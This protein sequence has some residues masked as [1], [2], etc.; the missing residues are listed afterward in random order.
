MHLESMEDTLLTVLITSAIVRGDAQELNRLLVRAGQAQTRRPSAGSPIYS[1]RLNLN[2]MDVAMQMGSKEIVSVWLLRCG[3][4]AYYH[5]SRAIRI[6]A[7]HGNRGALEALIKGS[8]DRTSPE[9]IH[10]Q[11]VRV[12]CDAIRARQLSA[13]EFL[14]PHVSQTRK[15]TKQEAEL[16][17][18][19]GGD[20]FPTLLVKAIESSDPDLVKW[21]FRREDFEVFGSDRRIYWPGSDHW[22]ACPYKGP[23]WVA[24]HDCKASSRPAIVEMLLKNGFDPNDLRHGV[25]RTL[26]ECAVAMKDAGTAA[27]LVRYGAD[28]SVSGCRAFKDG[29][30]PPLAR[31]IDDRSTFASL[32]GLL[33]KTGARRSWAW[34]GKQYTLN[35]D[36]KVIGHIEVVLRELGFDEQ[37]VQQQ[38]AGFCI[39]VN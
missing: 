3:G 28:V 36:A 8:K 22:N 2:P 34:K 35:T 25:K 15:R 1:G 9:G 39:L 21:C 27:L 4:L 19:T 30:K 33:L 26:L 10:A 31:A 32:V 5:G 29:E 14:G 23:L 38:N 18:E 17:P 24:M 12:L 11:L 13:V 7:Q 16:D 6:A 20:V 37:V